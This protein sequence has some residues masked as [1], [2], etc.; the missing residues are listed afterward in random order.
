MKFTNHFLYITN[1][2]ST[3]KY[4]IYTML[5]LMDFYILKQ[6]ISKLV[7]T[8][9]AF[10]VIFIV[11]DIID[12]LDKFI[13]ASMPAVAILKYYIYTIPWFVSIGFPMA[14]LLS[15][16][17]TLSILQKNSELTAI[18]ASGVGFRRIA[19]PLLIMGFIFSLLSFGFDNYVVTKHYQKRLLLEEEH[20]IRK[21]RTKNAK[22]RNIYRQLDANTILSIKR[23]QFNNK[24]A[25]GISIQ[26]FDGQSL[27]YRLDSP[28]MQWNDKEHSWIIPNYTIRQ[29]NNGQ[30]EFSTH[31]QDSTMYS[32]IT[33][34]DLTRE[35]G[36]PEEMDYKNLAEFVEKL[37]RNGIYEPRWA[38]NLHFKTALAGTSFLMVLFGLSLAIRKPRS[39]LAIGVGMSIGVIF[40]YYAVLKFGQTLGYKGVLDPF[41]SVWGPNFIFFLI[42]SYLFSRTKT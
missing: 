2:N 23:F 14:M 30:L 8:T 18:K 12:H 36:K 10:I 15:T 29:W 7:A 1:R 27:T 35:T 37:Q 11:V 21:S 39:S 3:T 20:G 4:V 42:G 17:F 22:K 9:I 19:T 38:V 33:P 13:D 34:I 25:Y 16:V 5:K 32:E 24:M 31:N 6:F 26:K 40:L 28:K 41:I